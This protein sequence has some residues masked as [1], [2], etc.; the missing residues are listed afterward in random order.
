MTVR[1]Y[2]GAR[3]VPVFMGDWDIDADYE[4]LSI[5][6]YQ[7]NSYTSRQKVP[8]GTDITNEQY[9]AL[10]GN[11]NAQID[12]YR[13]EVAALDS[14]VD[15]IDEIIPFSD[16]SPSSTVKDYVD[17]SIDT[18][19]GHAKT[20]GNAENNPIFYG[21]D[22]T[23]VEDSTDAIND[24]IEANQG[25][26]VIFS[27]G[28]YKVTDAIVTPYQ[29]AKRVSI[30]FNGAVI[31]FDG[32]TAIDAVLH[33]GGS[34]PTTGDS[35]SFY[36]KN[37]FSNF[38][39]KSNANADY[40][41]KIAN[42][43]KNC[44]ILNGFIWTA[45]NGIIISDD[46]ATHPSDAY[47][48]N[49]LIW[50]SVS[51]NASYN[52]ITIYGSDNKFNYIRSYN[53]LHDFDV[54]ADAN[55]F[56]MIHTLGISSGTKNGISYRINVGGDNFFSN[57]YNDTKKTCIHL[58]ST[59]T[60]ARVFVTNA[61]DYSYEHTLDERVFVN[62]Y[63]AQRAKVKING[64]DVSADETSNLYRL[65]VPYASGEFGEDSTTCFNLESVTTNGRGYATN[66]FLPND[67]I[68]TANDANTNI[69]NSKD[70]LW[71]ECGCL[72]GNNGKYITIL[73]AGTSFG[74]IVTLGPDGT[75]RTSKLLYG[76][77]FDFGTEPITNDLTG[78]T[79]K[80]C[81]ILLKVS[82]S[83]A[84]SINS[85]AS[86]A[87]TRYARPAFTT[88]DAVEFQGTPTNTATVA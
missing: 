80:S 3:Y 48:N 11:Y 35:Q 54:Y 52:G 23:G 70:N 17:T 45:K 75:I 81:K 41:I 46:T 58:M 50:N 39:I 37:Y 33:I 28:T 85:L 68:R 5:V 22:P 53:F 67:Y 55:Y 2:V 20:Y 83:K 62:A 40:S 66:L 61:K 31:D 73:I 18:V 1:E 10:T 71:T 57:I 56:E 59:A 27:P 42:N 24:C 13:Q 72:I 84:F 77:S 21:A 15:S 44:C 30:D 12:Q 49:L 25:G 16:F 6:Q 19:E 76:D 14:H 63:N 47:L 36:A 74:G 51:A 9:W 29:S 26:M 87:G 82:G 79:V 32:D 69:Y 7:G 34:Y 8:H 65:F 43:Y 4:P 78:S 86:Q 60:D 38:T 88:A 64:I